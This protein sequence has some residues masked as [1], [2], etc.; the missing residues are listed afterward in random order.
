M[1]FRPE[2]LANKSR[3]ALGDAVLAVPVSKRLLTLAAALFCVCLVALLMLGSYSR[4]ESVAGYLVPDKGLLK[5]YAPQQGAIVERLVEDGARVAKGDRLFVVTTERSSALTRD[6]DA[7]IAL[8]L[9]RSER[10][11]ADK[12]ADGLK[13]AE[14]ETTRLSALIEGAKRELVQLAGQSATQRE[15][16]ALAEQR[17]ADFKRLS[18]LG[19]VSRQEHKAQLDVVMSLRQQADELERALTERRNSVKDS[20]FALAQLPLKT[21]SAQADLRNALSEMKQRQMELEGRR[22]YSVVAPQAGRVTAIQGQVGQTAMPGVPLLAIVPQDSALEAHLYLP[23]RAAGFVAQ[24]QEVKLRYGAFPYQRFGLYAGRV[25]Q[26]D[27]TILTPNELPLPLPLSE[28]VY[29]LRA[30]LDAQAVDA[31]GQRYPLQAG[32]LLD[33]DIVLDRRP[34]WQW[35]LEPVLSLRGRL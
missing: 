3:F 19:H 35:L 9:R 22:V 24:G 23:T 34:L 33:A 15:R 21:A 31:Y 10:E 25:V 11:L 8:E 32:M 13:L 5:V 4:H 2:A 26:V 28:P 12:L 20:E 6:I 7:Q 14:L 18:A 17:S 27:S 29:R 1:L 16:L 30:R